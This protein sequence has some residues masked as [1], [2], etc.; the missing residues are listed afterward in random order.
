MASYDP[1]HDTLPVDQV[2]RAP[3]NRSVP[4]AAESYP[5]LVTFTDLADPKTVRRIDPGNLAA[6]F[7]PGYVLKAITLEITDEKTSGGRIENILRW[8]AWPRE[9]FLAAGGGETPLKVPGQTVGRDD[10]VSERNPERPILSKVDP[11]DFSFA[12]KLR[13]GH[14][15]RQ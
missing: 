7:G 1:G 5:L 10:F 11:H 6:S 3:R 8:L 12:A 2:E 13:Q 14:F 15:I 4:I 9:R